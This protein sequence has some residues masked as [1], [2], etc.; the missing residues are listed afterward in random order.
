LP[1]RSHPPSGA[2][3][4]DR[5][6]G[7]WLAAPLAAGTLLR[8]WNLPA[9]ILGGDEMHA[10]R[11]A[12]NS[13]LSEILV[14]Y[15]LSDNCIPLTAIYRLVLDAGGTLSEWVLRLP[16]LVSGLLLLA[17]APLW[18]ERR[19]G[20]RTA[21]VFA[22]L[23]AV[24]PMLV[25]YSRIA[26]SYMPM[27][28]LGGGAVAAFDAFWTTR[29]PRWA[30]AYAALAALALWFHL[31]AGPF[32]AAPLAFAAGDLAFRPGRRAAQL[33][34]PLGSL[35]ALTAAGLGFAVAAALF[36]LPARASLLSLVSAKRQAQEIPLR[37]ALD[38]MLL[39]AGTG[40]SGVAAL[41]W[42]LAL[43]GLA[44][45]AFRRPRLGL[46]VLTVGAGHV[47][48]ILLLSPLGLAH[49]WVLDRYLLPALPCAL[50]GIAYAFAEGGWPQR[51]RVPGAGGDGD[52][53]QREVE[54]AASRGAA[55]LRG[56][57]AA[58]FV[59]LLLV[60]GPFADAGLRR[61]S[62][63]HHDDMAGFYLP[64]AWLPP[65]SVPDFYGRL[66]AEGDSGAVIEYPWLFLWRFRSFYVYQE[67]HGRRVLVATPQRVV[68]RPELALANAIPAEPGAFCRNGARWLVVH[69]HVA[70]EEDR[71]VRPEDKAPPALNRELRRA[72]RQQ[73]GRM[74]ADLERLWGPPFYADQDIEA[75]DLAR[76][77]PKVE[78]G[79]PRR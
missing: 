72:L 68:R 46:Y 70:R 69:L 21:A 74:A 15:R 71:V 20:R 44:L 9:Q 19:L 35:A 52:A 43:G 31:G 24:S 28:L 30:A 49:P 41:F 55:T 50:L 65:Q 11:A 7:L 75:W 77:C 5:P 3:Q 61:S 73:A 23:L 29:K 63:M 27:L 54:E 64:R 42:G 40:H 4:P 53:H 79:G 12:L 67:I 34:S 45:L 16:M 48:G 8:L 51:S 2:A 78:T 57:A 36:L 60:A 18:I 14:T 62:F 58:A 33:A 6:G 39:Q 1:S 13:P 66:A 26:R 76:A 25:L 10:V 17:L 47:A 59:A 56:L 32:V 37:T 22:W 38:V